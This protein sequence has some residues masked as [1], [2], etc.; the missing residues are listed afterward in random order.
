MLHHFSFENFYSFEKKVEISFVLGKQGTIDNLSCITSTGERINKILAIIGPNGSGKTTIL[1]ALSFLR[2]FASNSFVELNP[3]EEIPCEPHFFSGN[4]P[5]FFQVVFDYQ[6][7]LYRY[8]L[9]L[10]KAKVINEALYIKTSKFYS[11]LFKRYWDEQNNKYTILQKDFGF[12]KKEAKKVRLNASLVSTAAQYG[13]P[14]AMTI[15]L[16]AK[17]IFSNVTEL[18]K[19]ASTPNKNDL[20][21]LSIT[22]SRYPLLSKQVSNLLCKMDLGLQGIAIKPEIHFDTSTQTNK[23]IEVPYGIHR[24]DSAEHLLELWYE[25][26]GT[27]RAYALLIILLPVLEMGGIAV[28]DELEA[29]LHPDM[30]IHLLQLFIHPETNPH[31]AQI[32]FS[33][34]SH[35]VLE[36]L[37]KDQVLLVEKHEDGNSEAW[38]LKDMEGV[39]RDDNLYAKYRAGTY[40]ALPNL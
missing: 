20:L 5:S 1:K 24:R 23:Q 19:L 31:Q 17:E 11:Y 8:E 27:Q 29:D 30:L 39:R 16:A 13:V 38:L 36:L 40:G 2:W 3:N 12:D 26:S 32:I 37:S 33:T 25:S 10:T 22:F 14:I 15:Q 7:K 35:E 21:T 9:T 4:S 6:G 28:I 18:G 34:H